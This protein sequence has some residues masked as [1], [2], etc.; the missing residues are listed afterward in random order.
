MKFQLLALDMD[1]T[2]LSEDLSISHKNLEAIKAMEAEG[3]KIVLCSGRPKES[4]LKYIDILDI[5]N[6]DDYIVS[7][8]GALIHKIGG[9]EVFSKVIE[10]DVLHDLIDMGRAKNIDVQLYDDDLTV[11]KV[12]EKTEVYMGLTGLG[13]VLVHDLKTLDRSVKVL[14]NHV[15]GPELEAF[16]IELT[17]KYGH[18]FNIFYSKPNY[19]EVLNIESSKG[20]ALA[21]LAEELHIPREAV[22][23]MG[24]GFNDVSMIEYAGVGIAVANAPDGVKERADYVTVAT[25]NESAVWEIY[26]K[27][28]LGNN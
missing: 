15:A 6:E 11:E 28:F 19:I 10:G 7:F 25:H 24:D 9:H 17:E 27:Y 20:L 5:H 14:F 22:V 8:N 23:A 2:L 26:N 4:M 13:S 1:D 21:Y 12:T 18:V 16:R 3:V